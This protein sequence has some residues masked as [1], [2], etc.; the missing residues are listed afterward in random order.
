MVYN[1]FVEQHNGNHCMCLSLSLRNWW[2]W[3]GCGADLR[4]FFFQKIFII[5]FNI[6]RIGKIRLHRTGTAVKRLTLI[7]LRRFEWTERTGGCRVVTLKVHRRATIQLAF[8]ESHEMTSTH[9]INHHDRSQN[10]FK[11]KTKKLTVNNFDNTEVAVLEMSFFWT[12]YTTIYWIY[13]GKYRARIMVTKGD[14]ADPIKTIRL[15]PIRLQFGWNQSHIWQQPPPSTPASFNR[16]WILRSSEMS[17]LSID[18]VDV[19]KV[20]LGLLMRLTA[21][22]MANVL[23]VRSAHH[24]IR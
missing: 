11:N 19:I 24:T 1:A 5:F 18:L 6:F 9:V 12:R 23:P 10:Y 13:A 3:C 14:A 21:L 17:S 15:C 8:D 2:D 22:E 20:D 7:Q 16:N 4:I